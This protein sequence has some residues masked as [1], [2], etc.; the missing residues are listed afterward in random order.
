MRKTSCKWGFTLIELLVVVLII[1]ILAAVALPQYKKAVYK[2]R[3]ATLK[4]LT[5][6]V[7]NAQEVYYLANG[8]YA[9]RFDELDVDVGGT[10]ADENDNRRNFD[11]GDCS[12]PAP[13]HVRCTNSSID[14]RYQIY[15]QHNSSR[16]YSGLIW[17]VDLT[18]NSNSIQSQICQQETNNKNR[19]VGVDAILWDY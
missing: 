5:K 7:A 9:D 14:M 17:C 11:W 19:T 16:Y 4:N 8:D 12:M 6:S 18:K 13:S 1:G 2:S 3:Y 10:S 15:F